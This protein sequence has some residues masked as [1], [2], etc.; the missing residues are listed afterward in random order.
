[1][2]ES[3]N[4]KRIIVGITGASGVRY[5]VRLVECLCGAQLDVHLIVTPNGERL[6]RDEAGIDEVSANALLGGQSDHLFT[7]SYRDVGANPASGSYR[8]DGMVICPCSSNTLAGVS[9]G[10]AGN[11]L[12][13]AAAVTLKEARRLIVVPREMPMS[14]M[15]LLNA[16]R[17][18]EA[19]AIICPA[20]PGFYM[21]PG[22]IGDLVDFVVGRLLDLLS[23]PHGLNT[24]WADRLEPPRNM[25]ASEPDR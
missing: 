15:D 3:G 24:R 25:S 17:L 16:L 8:T 21:Q 18:S 19:G 12:D 13:R 11:L 6:L 20:S 2:S 4:T 7:H 10:L 9:A 5:A 1:M 14:R 23:V 22:E